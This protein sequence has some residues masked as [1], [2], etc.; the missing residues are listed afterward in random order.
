MEQIA[1]TAFFVF[2]TVSSALVTLGFILAFTEFAMKT[3]KDIIWEWRR[4]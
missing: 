4:R 2:F 3:V 1:T